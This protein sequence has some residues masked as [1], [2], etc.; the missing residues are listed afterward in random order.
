V[1]TRRK[2]PTCRRED[3][4]PRRPRTTMQRSPD[5]D[6]G[7]D[8]AG[9]SAVRCGPGHRRSVPLGDQGRERRRGKEVA[10]VSP[11][12]QPF[13]GSGLYKRLIP[14]RGCACRIGCA[15]L[16]AEDAQVRSPTGPFTNVASER[17]RHRG[18]PVSG[19]RG[20]SRRSPNLARVKPGSTWPVSRAAAIG[21][22]E[23]GNQ[24]CVVRVVTGQGRDRTERGHQAEYQRVGREHV[25]QAE[26]G[27]AGP[28]G[29]VRGGVR[30]SARASGR[31]P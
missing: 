2:P 26:P 22:V 15:H 19:R 10:L 1:T 17:R 3:D 4:A 6:S 14:R 20:T 13:G 12:P 16:G 8:T 31:R 18:R 25:C 21:G 29:G 11:P 23:P 28:G 24:F 7:L 27:A 30:G 9:S 5:D